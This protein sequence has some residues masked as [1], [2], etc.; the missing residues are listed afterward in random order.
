MSSKIIE[1]IQPYLDNTLDPALG[2][3]S[4]ITGIFG[5]RPSV[6]AKSPFLWNEAFRG[7]DLDAAFAPFD[8]SLENLGTLVG[9]LREIPAYLGGSVTVPYKTAIMDFLDEVDTRAQ[10][11]GAVN[12]VARTSDGRL[13]GFNTDAQGAIDSIKKQM[14]GQ[15]APFLPDLTGIRVLL[16]G[17]GGAGKA[18]AFAIADEVGNSGRVVIANRSPEHASDL[19]KSVTDAYGNAESVSEQDLA[20]VLSE[21]QLV[22]NASVRGQS[23][24]R[25]LPQGQVTCLEPYSALGPASPAVMTESQYPDT[26]SLLRAWYQASFDDISA[27]HARSGQ[28]IFDANTQTAYLD[29]IYSP[30]ESTLLRQ[31][32]LA[33]HATLNGKGM[34][35]AQAV[36]GLVNRVMKPFFEDQGWQTD[37]LYPK[38]FELMAQV[39]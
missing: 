6:S 7:L 5:D 14:P 3:R 16:L 26:S 2:E 8:V 11:I 39:W 33:G 19:A 36:D 4:V 22:I 18:V 31:A 28:A 20:P 12:T 17:S 29:I 15:Q 38:V 27:N 32:R 30:L 34:N 25:Q 37:Q 35:L 21:T 1:Q 10:Q 13:I 24:L 23:G 9:A